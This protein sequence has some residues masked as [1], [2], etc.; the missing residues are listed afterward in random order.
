MADTEQ[1]KSLDARQ[2]NRE[3]QAT[4]RQRQRDDGLIELRFGWGTIEEKRILSAKLQEVRS[5]VNLQKSTEVNTEK[6]VLTEK[7]R[8][9]SPTPGM[10]SLRPDHHIE[11]LNAIF[12]DFLADLSVP[13]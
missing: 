5:A 4:F 3:K 1:T 2:K 8:L 12:P 11:Q 13:K 7:P 10:D 6:H 9:L